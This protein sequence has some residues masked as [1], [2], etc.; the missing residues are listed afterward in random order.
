MGITGHWRAA[1]LDQAEGHPGWVVTLADLLL[2]DGDT[3]SLLRGGA[4]FGQVD[5]YLRRAG[6]NPDAIDVLAAVA[7]LGGVSERE[8]SAC[9]GHRHSAISRGS[10]LEHQRQ[11]RPTPPSDCRASRQ[12]DVPL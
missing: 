12:A 8:S 7:T 10:D 4:L 11:E 6:I 9:E 5:R 2:R 1:I 3:D